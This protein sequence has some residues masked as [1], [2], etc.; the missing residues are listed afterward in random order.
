MTTTQSLSGSSPII[1]LSQPLRGDGFLTGT[2]RP[3]YGSELSVAAAPNGPGSPSTTELRLTALSIKAGTP[4]PATSP[5]PGPLGRLSPLPSGGLPSPAVPSTVVPSTMVPSTV[6]PSVTVPSPVLP[7]ATSVSVPPQ[8]AERGAVAGFCMPAIQTLLTAALSRLTASAASFFSAA[9]LAFERFLA[10]L[11]PTPPPAG[12]GQANPPAASSAGATVPSGS[13]V[14]SG[15]TGPLSTPPTVNGNAGSQVSPPPPG[16]TSLFR[17]KLLARLS[18]EERLSETELRSA[19]VGFQ[20]YQKS[21]ALE[22]D[23]YSAL[24]AAE[25]RGEPVNDA[26]LSALGTLSAAGGITSDEVRW[27]YSLSA[28]AAQLDNNLTYLRTTAGAEPSF[29]LQNALQIAEVNLAKIQ[30]GLIK[31]PLLTVQ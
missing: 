7:S 4:L 25:E 18:G 21:P 22:R 17:E 3:A 30:G 29:E 2:I 31:V 23:Y 26:V 10:R 24:K 27:V 6:V 20:L 16:G 12:T 8:S 1:P 9:G 13:A 28:R 19:I 11:A 15:Q 14:P 5:M